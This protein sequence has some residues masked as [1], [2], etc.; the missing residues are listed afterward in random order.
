MRT[1][2]IEATRRGWVPQEGL[3]LTMRLL[4]GTIA[5]VVVFDRPLVA[6]GGANPSRDE[7]IDHVT[8]VFLYGARLAKD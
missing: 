7:V 4:F 8:R 3:A 5:S 1:T 6:G 2:S